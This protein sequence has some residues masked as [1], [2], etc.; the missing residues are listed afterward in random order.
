MR[1][2]ALIR[3]LEPTDVIALA[4]FFLV[5]LADGAERYFHP[6][7]LDRHGAEDVCNEHEPDYF[8]GG[9]SEK[10][11]VAYGMLRGWK[12]GFEFPSLGL[13]VHPDFR[14]H[15]WGRRI[16]DHLHNVALARNCRKIRLTAY[17]ENAQAISLFV[18]A[19]YRLEPYSEDRAV[20]WLDL[21]SGCTPTSL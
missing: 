10:R 1:E 17:R 8:C 14:N 7:P 13:A 2:S 18:K 5:L 3:R 4:D 9:F 12:D 19:G 11:L 16:L 6:H 20:A 15:G 21:F